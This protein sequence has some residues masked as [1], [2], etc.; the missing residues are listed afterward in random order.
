MD[1]DKLKDLFDSFDPELSSDIRFLS[2]LQRNMDA[3]ELVKQ[4]SMATRKRNKV[5]V[6]VAA[7]SGFVMGVLIMLLLPFIE[8]WISTINFTIPYF[9]MSSL[10]VDLQIA[11]WMLASVVSGFTAFNIYEIVLSRMTSNE[12]AI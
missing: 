6:A 3:V 4:R 5:A 7:L 10:T 2:K 1:D 9:S 12:A 8:D 11:G